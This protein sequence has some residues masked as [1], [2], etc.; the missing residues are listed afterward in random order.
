MCVSTPRVMLMLMLIDRSITDTRDHDRLSM[1]VLL[2]PPRM[3]KA[4]HCVRDFH[5]EMNESP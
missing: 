1:G 5:P 4:G 2:L 3:S